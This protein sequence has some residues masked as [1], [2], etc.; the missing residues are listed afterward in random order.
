MTPAVISS[1]EEK[2][3]ITSYCGGGRKMLRAPIS[4]VL[5]A[6]R[7][8]SDV[9]RDPQVVCEPEV[10]LIRLLNA[11]NGDEPVRSLMRST[12]TIRR[13]CTGACEKRLR[14][15]M[16]SLT[17]MCVYVCV[18]PPSFFPLAP[19]SACIN[20]YKNALPTHYCY[21]RSSKYNGLR[22]RYKLD[23][24]LALSYSFLRLPV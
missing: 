4:F 19:S 3:R 1:S 10:F 18:S 24:R 9:V 8:V 17:I 20:V 15:R 6:T 5:R 16:V 22:R 7:R 11:Y 14:S 13:L 23:E 12:M 21:A 2:S